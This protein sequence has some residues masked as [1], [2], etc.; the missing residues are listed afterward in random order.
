MNRRIF[1]CLDDVFVLQYSFQADAS[2]LIEKAEV[3]GSNNKHG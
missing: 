3:Y 2:I 1:K